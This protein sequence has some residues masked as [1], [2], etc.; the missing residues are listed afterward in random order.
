[1]VDMSDTPGPLSLEQVEAKLKGLVVKHLNLDLDP[2][3]I[4]CDE[5]D[6]L[7]NRGFN[8]IDALE[9]LISVEQ[10]FDIQID[11]ED[12]D[13]SLLRTLRVLSRYITT[14]IEK[15]QPS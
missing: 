5:E 12:L 3:Q 11:D 15:R 9:L 8:S 6:F 10:A 2:E 4:D 1:M 14:A 7:T 13:A